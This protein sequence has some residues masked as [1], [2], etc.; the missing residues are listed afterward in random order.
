MSEHSGATGHAT[1]K[2]LRAGK[3]QMRVISYGPDYT[4]EQWCRKGH[5]LFVLE[6]ELT[7]EHE[8]GRRCEI[9]AGMSYHVGDDYGSP[10]RV[11]SISGA[12]IFVVD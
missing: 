1:Q 9:G 8:N 12:T 7:I 4:A 5:I 11:S 3:A 10:H 6:G 2:T